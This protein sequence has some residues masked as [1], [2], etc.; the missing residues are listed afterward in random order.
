MIKVLAAGT[1][2][3]YD[4]KRHGDVRLSEHLKVKDFRSYSSSKKKLYSNEV[5]IYTGLPEALEKLMAYLGANKI[6][7]VN[8][9]R[10]PEHNAAVGGSKKSMHLL[11][12]AADVRLFKNGKAI[13]GKDICLVAEKLGFAGI[14]FMS[15]NSV[16]L[17]VSPSRI[18]RGDETK[19]E[20]GAYYSLTKHK[21]TFEKYFKTSTSEPV[22]VKSDKGEVEY[23]VEERRILFDGRDLD[24]A[25]INHDGENYMKIKD[26]EK[27]GFKVSSAGSMPIVAMDMIKCRINGKEKDI[28]GINTGGRTYTYLRE[29]AEALECSVG[30]ENSIK[31]VT[32]DT[33]GK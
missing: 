25:A 3:V 16:H 32:I 21:L 4:L 1:K 14:G 23:M 20:N 7:I 13:S 33:K 22:S 12:L 8:G 11:G 29:T 28:R 31:A 18:W 10:C 24:I 19:K 30:W 27:M 26:L 15:N 17:D 6:T 2:Q 5:I 9:Y